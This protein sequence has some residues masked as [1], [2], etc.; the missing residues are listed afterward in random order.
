MDCCGVRSAFGE[1]GSYS[2][3]SQTP[4]KEIGDMDDDLSSKEVPLALLVL[5]AIWTFS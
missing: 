4:R 5:L 1:N 2:L 3:L